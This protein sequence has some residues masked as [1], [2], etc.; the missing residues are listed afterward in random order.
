MPP[1]W[2]TI[3]QYDNHYQLHEEL[4]IIQKG[5]K[6]PHYRVTHEYSVKGNGTYL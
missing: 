5:I 1:S 6:N 4:S 3:I 2:I